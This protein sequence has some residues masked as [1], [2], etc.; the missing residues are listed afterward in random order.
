M[1]KPSRQMKREA[2]RA[3]KRFEAKGC[4]RCGKGPIAG[5]LE[6]L[7]RNPAGTLSAVHASCARKGDAVLAVG[8][9]VAT[10]PKHIADD[11]QWFE[12]NPSRLARLR[13]PFD[14]GETKLLLNHAYLAELKQ[15]GQSSFSD[16]M[17]EILR[18]TDPSRVA[19][20]VVRKAP[21]IRLRSI[22]ILD[23]GFDE[24]TAETIEAVG[25]GLLTDNDTEVPAEVE[26]LRNLFDVQLLEVSAIAA[27]TTGKPSLADV[28][29]AVGESRFA[30]WH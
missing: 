4:H 14:A 2:D 1:I 20:L 11:R 29:R 15:S 6:A 17:R 5:L 18:K 3:F 21:G 25:A 10:T 16:R 22:T 12:A 19:I 24:V 27:H 23:R 13:V 26:Y 8:T 30:T 28:A 9:F 7:L